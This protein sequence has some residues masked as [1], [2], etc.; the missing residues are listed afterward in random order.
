MGDV[1]FS[2]IYKGMSVLLSN[3]YPIVNIEYYKGG[4]KCIKLVYTRWIC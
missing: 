1:S 4:G 2:S 3:N